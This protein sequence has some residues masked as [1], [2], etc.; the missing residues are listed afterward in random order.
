MKPFTRHYLL[1]GWFLLLPMVIGTSPAS[2]H[3][4]LTLTDRLIEHEFRVMPQRPRLLNRRQIGVYLRVTDNSGRDHRLTSSAIQL[5]QIGQ[6]PVP[7]WRLGWQALANP[8]QTV[9]RLDGFQAYFNQDYS[10]LKSLDRAFLQQNRLANRIEIRRIKHK[11]VAEAGATPKTGVKNSVKLLLGNKLAKGSALAPQSG[12]Q[13]SGKSQPSQ[14]LMALLSHQQQPLRST[15]RYLNDSAWSS[16]ERVVLKDQAINTENRNYLNYLKHLSL[17]VR[18]TRIL[19]AGDPQQAEISFAGLDRLFFFNAAIVNASTT[20]TPESFHFR[21]AELTVSPRRFYSSESVNSAIPEV[22]GYLDTFETE[23]GTNLIVV[24]LPPE[25]LSQ[26]HMS[27]TVQLKTQDEIIHELAL[28]LDLNQEIAESYRCWAGTATEQRFCDLTIG[29]TEGDR[30]IMA[31]WRGEKRESPWIRQDQRI[32]QMFADKDY[33]G[34]IILTLKQMPEQK[35]GEAM[36][37]AL[38]GDWMF[39]TAEAYKNRGKTAEALSWYR[40]I[41]REYPFSDRYPYA[42]QRLMEQNMKHLFEP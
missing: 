1:V 41:I 17:Q 26:V 25:T 28:N 10:T 21:P 37:L 15:G 18:S 8:Y 13:F 22:K 36:P 30:E 33:E 34:L 39:L 14:K 11:M 7:V 9:E 3:E 4:E 2:A 20:D 5:V 19:N 12:Y 27:I 35:A 42:W 32:R 38:A 6:Q 16:H 29:L 40:A 23:L 24:D 31:D